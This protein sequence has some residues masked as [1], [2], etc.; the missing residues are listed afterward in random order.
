MKRRPSFLVAA[1][2]VFGLFAAACSED[3][4]SE[5]GTPS[6]SSA[7]SEGSEP[8]DD[9]QTD[10]DPADAKV[11][12]GTLE[13]SS[14]EHGRAYTGGPGGE[15]SGE[16]IVIG[17]VNQEGGTVSFPEA[18]IGA[19]AAV[20]FANTYLGGVGGRP[21]ELAKC[22]VT[23]EEDGQ[24]CAQEMIANPD[25]QV[26]LAGALNNGS[27]PLLDGLAGKKPVFI[28][29]PLTAPDFG[30]KDAFAFSPGAPGVVTGLSIFVAKYLADI[31]GTPIQKVAVVFNDNPIG[32]IAFGVL[33]KPVLER[34]GITD[35]TGVAV[36]D[37]AG[38]QE[39][40]TAIQAAGAEDADVFIPLVVVQSCIGVYEALKTL[41][42]T[43]PVATSGLCFGIPMQVHLRE[44]GEGGNL[45]NGWYFGGYGY[46]Y[47]IRGNADL[48][49]YVD[50]VFAFAAETGLD[51]NSFEYTGFGGPTFGSLM[52]LL[53]FLNAGAESSDDF[54]AAA[55]AFTGP[56][57][58]VVGAQKCGGNPA[59]PSLCGF[60]IGIQQQQ[61]T[62]YASVRDGYN[63]KAIDIQAELPG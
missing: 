33:T 44:A 26:V 21:I 49:S 8:A 16:P 39:M 40:A 6:E 19:E 14:V 12:D 48:D 50:T 1:V 20:W 11:K 47:D 17:Y 3:A 29:N 46:S 25:V 28:A 37:T 10:V 61:G 18:S 15:T 54:R 36:P 30:A 4:T 27:A 55:T 24:K 62:E 13:D 42:I 52:L 59:F 31:V 43:T 9:A 60:Q 22:T 63:G 23:K 58:G 34:F 32:Q 45:P 5:G 41:E 53:Q 38:P 2:T 56:M 51:P 35:V 7:I 57:W